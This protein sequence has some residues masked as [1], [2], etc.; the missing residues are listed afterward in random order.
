MAMAILIYSRGTRIDDRHAEDDHVDA[1]GPA[2]TELPA[3]KNIGFVSTDS[4]QWQSDGINTVIGEI[5]QIS[6]STVRGGRSGLSVARVDHA[7]HTKP[8]N[9]RGSQCASDVSA[10]PR[11]FNLVNVTSQDSISPSQRLNRLIVR[12]TVNTYTQIIHNL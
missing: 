7:K 5:G 2:G 8:K 10:I 1:N 12:V 3:A 9:P 4:I 11:Y 6:T